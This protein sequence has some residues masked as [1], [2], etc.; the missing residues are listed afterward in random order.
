[1]RT[2]LLTASLFAA[3][4]GLMPAAHA[5]GPALHFSDIEY[6][7]ADSDRVARAQSLL[8]DTIPAGTPLVTAEA[9]LSDAGAR[10]HPSRRDTNTVQC[11]YHEMSAADE[12]FDD[13][14]WTTRLSVSDGTIT[15]VS[16]SRDVDRHGN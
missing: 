1:M 2:P 14:R 9:V 10:C 5:A 4:F 16:V 12:S 13:I 15:A 6:S 11:L 7:Y 8:G 3:G